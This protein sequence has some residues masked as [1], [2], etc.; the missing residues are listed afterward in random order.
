M[1]LLLIT[2]GK[3]LKKYKPGFEIGSYAAKKKNYLE[4]TKKKM[5]SPKD[6]YHSSSILITK[7]LKKDIDES[8]P[9]IKLHPLPYTDP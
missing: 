3:D 6:S 2:N 4:Q 7:R 1:W 9:K 8:Q 5:C